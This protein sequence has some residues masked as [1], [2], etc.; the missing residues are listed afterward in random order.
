[1]DA[2]DKKM[3]TLELADRVR[4]FEIGLFWTRS[5]FFWGFTATALAGYGAAFHAKR[6]GLQFGAA[7]FGLACGMAWT[8]VNRGSKYWQL[9]WET[10]VKAAQEDA[11]LTLELFSP[12]NGEPMVPETWVWGAKH[13][14]VSGIAIAFS[15]FSVLVWL[16]LI[17][18]ATSILSWVPLGFAELMALLV[19]LIYISWSQY[20]AVGAVGLVGQGND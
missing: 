18:E 4:R 20:F 1:M 12:K 11:A 7:C 8:L 6:P 14:S 15:D 16:G 9:V 19:T 13:L 17:L 2:D 3:K 5:L 10:K